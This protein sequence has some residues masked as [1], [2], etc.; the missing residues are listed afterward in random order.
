GDLGAADSRS[1]GRAARLCAHFAAAAGSGG[2]RHATAVLDQG[3]CGGGVNRFDPAAGDPDWPA[4][5]RGAILPRSRSDAD[6]A[7]VRAGFA[8]AGAAAGGDAP[9]IYRG[10]R[11]SPFT[12]AADR[13]GPGVCRCGVLSDASLHSGPVVAAV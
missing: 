7:A 10:Q 9:G 12:W 5:R 11:N 6:D 1:P 8:A 3:D 2:S 4:L 13:A